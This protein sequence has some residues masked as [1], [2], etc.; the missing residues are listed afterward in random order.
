MMLI[1]LE[2]V[3]C[4]PNDGKADIAPYAD[5]AAGDCEIDRNGMKALGGW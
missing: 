4:G 1:E 2:E 5:A 3:V